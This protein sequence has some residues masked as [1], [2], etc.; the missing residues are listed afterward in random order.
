MFGEKL[1]GSG[2][3]GK[4]TWLREERQ[5]KLVRRKGRKEV[6]QGKEGSRDI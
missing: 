6:S 1:I 3:K 5:E 4:I 2:K